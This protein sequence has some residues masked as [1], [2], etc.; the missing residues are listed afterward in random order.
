ML[1]MEPKLE[2]QSDLPPETPFDEPPE[3]SNL[4]I[5]MG[6]CPSSPDGNHN[7]VDHHTKGFKICTYCNGVYYG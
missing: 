1:L 4:P 5:C 7:L 2:S 6:D 3:S